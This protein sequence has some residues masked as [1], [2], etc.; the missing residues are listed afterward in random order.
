MSL[1]VGIIGCGLM[2]R[3]RSAALGEDRVVGA[4]DL[5]PEAAEGL[6]AEFGGTACATLDELLALSPDVVIV[7]T[8][9]DQIAPCAVAAL[10]A[11]AH[12]L[13]EKPAGI[14]VADVDRIA[15]AAQA[16]GRIAKVGFNHRF[17]PAIS[18]AIET[19]RSG[20]FGDVLFLRG[21]YGHGGRPGYDQE[22]RADPKTGGGG[23]M[24]D[25]GMH[26]LDLS[27]W[28]LGELPL[29][30]A[31]LRTSFW[32][33][34]VED[35]AAILLGVPG[36]HRA[37]WATLHVTWTEWTNLFSLEITC[38]TGKLVVDGLQGSYGPQ[39]LS[40]FTMDPVKMGKPEAEIIAFDPVDVSWGLEWDSVRA[41]I[42]SGAPVPEDLASV[43]YCWDLIEQAYAA[44]GYPTPGGET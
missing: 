20:R 13:V 30:S 36:D 43:R 6:V 34:P 25:Q 22:W 29:H 41:A 4:Y 42:A 10:Q 7:A 5:R 40:I 2:G 18:Q 14:G 37:P 9:H 11:G 38:R 12:V 19:A 23:E 21:R 44:N 1:Q 15:A 28:L 16:A 33:M 24:T 8:S 31:L 39:K 27:H 35:N 32:D 26:L 17:H 3:K